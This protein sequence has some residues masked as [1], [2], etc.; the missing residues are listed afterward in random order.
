MRVDD[1][2]S[3]PLN[4]PFAEVIVT[5]TTSRG[6]GISEILVTIHGGRRSIVTTIANRGMATGAIA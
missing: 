4:P 6:V 3:Q 2:S 5:W 1:S